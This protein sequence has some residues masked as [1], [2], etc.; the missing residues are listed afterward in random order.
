MYGLIVKHLNI[1]NKLFI[2]RSEEAL[3]C[4]STFV[5]LALGDTPKPCPSRDPKNPEVRKS[6]YY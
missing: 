6:R 3:A 2:E 4:Q 5:C 1:L